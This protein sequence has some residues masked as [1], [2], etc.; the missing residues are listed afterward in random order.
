LAFSRYVFQAYQPEQDLDLETSDEVAGIIL[1]DRSENAV[2][3]H[4]Q[5]IQ[6][7][8]ALAVHIVISQI[9]PG[10]LKSKFCSF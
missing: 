3:R 4:R 8:W 2:F 10:D 6:H 5:S 1:V 7:S 9:Q